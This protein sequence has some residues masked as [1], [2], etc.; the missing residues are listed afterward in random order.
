MRKIGIIGLG[1]V[2]ALLANLL[3][4]QQAADELVLIDSDADL[5][6][7]LQNDLLDGMQSL[8]IQ[9]NIKI[10]DY[11]ALKD[12]D[13]IVLAIGKAELLK[14]QR[15]AELTFV[16]ETMR[17]IAPQIKQSGFDGILLNLANP[18]EVTTAYLQYLTAL[19]KNK[20]IGMG[21]VLDTARLQRA[22]ADQVQVA[23]SAVAGWVYG[24]HD[25]EAVPIWS[26]FTVNGQPL[27]KPV[28]GHKID[29]HESE[30]QAKLNGWY[31]IKGQ[32][33]D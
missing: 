14:E 20:V 19:P 26:T 23:S 8:S 4:A 2:G 3:V 9:P 21:T 31:A 33:Q 32:G 1:N 22:I 15:F 28:L 7:G 25:G 13:A 24:Q 16:G 30:I 10:Q 12:A 5:A 27:E 17:Q 11:A 29:P 6:L 18:N